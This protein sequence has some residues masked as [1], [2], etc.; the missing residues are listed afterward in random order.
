M[1]GYKIAEKLEEILA[2]GDTNDYQEDWYR[3]QIEMLRLQLIYDD[4]RMSEGC[5]LHDKEKGLIL[6]P[7]S[8]P[9]PWDKVFSDLLDYDDSED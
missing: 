2:R 7:L 9:L 4:T 8:G 6:A 5:Y 1:E 3:D